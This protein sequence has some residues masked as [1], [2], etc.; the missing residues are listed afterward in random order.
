[1]NTS[2]DGAGM[3]HLERGGSSVAP[4]SSGV[5]ER[6]RWNTQMSSFLSM[7]MPPTWP[8][9][10]LLGSGFGQNGSTLNVGGAACAAIA[11]THRTSASTAARDSIA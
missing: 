7:N 3:Q 6:G 4:F 1:L 9:I 10:Q 5:T 11:P 2:T 8:M